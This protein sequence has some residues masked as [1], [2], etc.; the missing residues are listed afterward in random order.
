[1]KENKGGYCWD[2]KS[3]RIAL[4]KWAISKIVRWH[5]KDDKPDLIEIKQ[6]STKEIKGRV[7]YGNER[8]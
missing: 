3:G 1:M 8:K 2:I 7:Y 4:Y 5:N 6:T